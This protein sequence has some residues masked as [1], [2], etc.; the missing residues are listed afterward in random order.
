ML[1]I[2]LINLVVLG[3]ILAFLL[4][5]SYLLAGSMGW[6]EERRPGDQ[7]DGYWYMSGNGAPGCF[8]DLVVLKINNGKFSHILRGTSVDVPIRSYSGQELVIE[9]RTEPGV[10]SRFYVEDR[11]QVLWAYR[12][13]EKSGEAKLVKDSAMPLFTTCDNPST[14]GVLSSLVSKVF[15]PGEPTSKVTIRRSS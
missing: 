3:G 5:N 7:L 6:D 10:T 13:E 14:M 12:Y 15:D 9:F 2:I 8:D 1:K 4:P 11:G